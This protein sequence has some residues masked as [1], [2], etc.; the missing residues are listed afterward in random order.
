MSRN[1][2]HYDEMPRIDDIDQIK[3]D[4]QNFLNED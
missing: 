1:R 4:M 3:K 2:G